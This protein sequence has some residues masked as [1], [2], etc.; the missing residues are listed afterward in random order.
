MI[1]K[2]DTTR[3]TS[4]P[5]TVNEAI[6][7]IVEDLTLL[8][9]IARTVQDETN[10]LLSEVEGMGENI[11]QMC[12]KLECLQALVLR[13]PDNSAVDAGTKSKGGTEK[14]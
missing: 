2:K 4:E 6:Y 11:R 10:C 3:S 7:Q 8:G 1:T 5:L 12:K 14:C 13:S 9:D